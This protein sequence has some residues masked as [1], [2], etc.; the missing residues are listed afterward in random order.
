MVKIQ[1]LAV[2]RML[3]PVDCIC[4]RQDGGNPTDVSKLFANV[5]PRRYIRTK[6]RGTWGDQ[7]WSRHQTNKDRLI[8]NSKPKHL[9]N[10]KG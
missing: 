5:M 9:I 1:D 7:Q 2:R 8:N 10:D 4:L 3:E 6:D